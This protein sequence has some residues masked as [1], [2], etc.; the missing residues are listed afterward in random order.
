MCKG[1]HQRTGDSICIIV[2]NTCFPLIKS[3]YSLKIQMCFYHQKTI[4]FIYPFI[5]E[6]INFVELLTENIIINYKVTNANPK[7]RCR[8]QVGQC[9]SN[10]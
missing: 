6:Q 4:N 2:T 8:L 3:F 1:K 10:F 9:D 5:L 7:V